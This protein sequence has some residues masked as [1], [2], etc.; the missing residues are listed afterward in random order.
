[1]SWCQATT[2]PAELHPIV[3][4][5]GA[6][7]GSL[8][9]WNRLLLALAVGPRGGDTGRRACGS[10]DRPGAPPAR[11]RQGPLRPRRARSRPRRRTARPRRLRSNRSG[12]STP[13]LGS[14]RGCG[15]LAQF[16]TE[17]LSSFTRESSRGT[18]RMTASRSSATST[19]TRRSGAWSRT[20]HESHSRSLPM[21]SSAAAHR[22]APSGVERPRLCC[23]CV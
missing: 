18:S 19:T 9:S 6:E 5:F 10:K 4:G 3:H 14:G 22:V 21:S 15:R 7:A 8:A 1:M 11:A 13:T 23:T 16:R 12:Y 17:P 2:A 20:M